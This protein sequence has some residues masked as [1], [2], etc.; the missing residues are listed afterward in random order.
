MTNNNMLM[1]DALL[2]LCN[3]NQLLEVQKMVNYEIGNRSAVAIKNELLK[4]SPLKKYFER[5]YFSEEDDEDDNEKTNYFCN[6]MF[7]NDIGI[8]I[9]CTSKFDIEF[10]A[11]DSN[12]D[13]HN[14]TDRTKIVNLVLDWLGVDEYFLN[15]L[16]DDIDK[17]YSKYLSKFNL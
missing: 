12:G 7:I 16:S 4:D 1:L 11:Y 2:K 6:I 9:K 13:V 5:I 3:D 8:D 14:E 10:S 15:T 17:I